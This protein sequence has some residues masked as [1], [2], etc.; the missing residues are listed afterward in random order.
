MEFPWMIL[1]LCALVR[2]QSNRCTHE[3]NPY[4][5]VFRDD[6]GLLITNCRVHTQRVHVRLDAE[7]VSRQ[8]ISPAAHMSW[9]RADWTTQAVKH[10]QLDTAHMLAQLQKF[11]VTQSELAEPRREKRFLRALLST[12]GFLL[13]LPVVELENIYRLKTVLNVG[14]WRDKT[15]VKIITPPVIAYQEHNPD[16][17]L[18][19]NLLMCTLTKDVHYLCPSKPLRGAIIHIDDLALYQLPDDRIDTDIEMPDAFAK[20]SLELPPAIQNQ[21]Q[22]EGLMTVHL[23]Y[24]GI[25]TCR[26]IQNANVLLSEYVSLTSMKLKPNSS[27]RKLNAHKNGVNMEK[28]MVARLGVLDSIATMLTYINKDTEQPQP[29]LPGYAAVY[30]PS[31]A[32]TLASAQ[33]LRQRQRL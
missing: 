3:W 14:F 21:I 20:H 6:P 11:T 9:D 32:V 25:D 19:P 8:H 12:V 28:N 17:Y 33:E 18:T 24:I 26:Q 7:N 29:G 15:H 22:Y 10:A 27:S 16:F 5:I 31:G 23:S 4:G 2:N 30:Q 13:M 1:T